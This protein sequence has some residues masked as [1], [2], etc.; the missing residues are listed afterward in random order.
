MTTLFE[1][2]NCGRL[3]AADKLPKCP[4]CSASGPMTL[5]QPT[6]DQAMLSTSQVLSSKEERR[7]FE[8]QRG[9]GSKPS[10]GATILWWGGIAFAIFILLV[11]LTTGFGS[12]GGNVPGKECFDYEK[13]NGDWANSCDL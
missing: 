13:P 9:N 6:G 3:Y 12:G 8:E 7:K 10:W 5:G 11:I 1:C 4:V 2:V